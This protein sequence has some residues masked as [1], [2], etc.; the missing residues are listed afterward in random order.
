MSTGTAGLTREEITETAKKIRRDVV[1]MTYA[2]K[3][4]HPGGPLSAA[5]YLTAAYFNHVRVDPKNPADD[6]RDIFIISNGHCSALHYSLLSR[7]GFFPPGYLM[8]FRSTGSGLDPPRHRSGPGAREA[9]RAD[10]FLEEGENTARRFC[11]GCGPPSFRR[12]CSGSQGLRGPGSVLGAA[13]S[14]RPGGHSE[15][16]LCF[17]CPVG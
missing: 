7:R 6:K 5:D 3:S 4:G 13:R 1:C 10:G 11:R 9:R 12:P 17:G 16:R 14:R 8:T 2:A 15:L